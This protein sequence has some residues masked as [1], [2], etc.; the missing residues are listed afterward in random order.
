[1]SLAPLASVVPV[2]GVPVRAPGRGGRLVLCSQGRSREVRSLHPSLTNLL[3]ASWTKGHTHELMPGRVRSAMYPAFLRRIVPQV[4]PSPQELT[5]RTKGA[6]PACSRRV[7]P[8]SPLQT[9]QHGDQMRCCGSAWHFGQSAVGC[10]G[11]TV[12]D[13]QQSSD[14]IWHV[15]SK[16][17]ERLLA[18]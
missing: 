4:S 3:Q 16:Q 5:P 10:A 18:C 12:L 2:T 9:A 15:P 14:S 13:V 11:F 8:L 17:H 6:L 7:G 1:M